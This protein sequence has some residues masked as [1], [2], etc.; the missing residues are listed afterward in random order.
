MVEIAG[1]VVIIMAILASMWLVFSISAPNRRIKKPD[2]SL[3]LMKPARLRPYGFKVSA[4]LRSRP[5]GQESVPKYSVI[6]LF[7]A[8]LG[9][10]TLQL[11]VGRRGQKEIWIVSWTCGRSC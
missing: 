7:Y 8:L 2:L 11:T 3:W 10:W 1:S 5:G 9:V 4:G 6:T